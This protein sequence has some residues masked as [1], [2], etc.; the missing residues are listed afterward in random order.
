M[1]LFRKSHQRALDVM[2]NTLE[3]EARSK[4]EVIRQ[5]KKLEQEMIDLE[6]LLEETNRARCDAEKSFKKFNE[7]I[8]DLELVVEDE[9]LA[10]QHAKDAQAAA[11]KK[12]AQLIA[13][14][15]VVRLELDASERSNKSLCSDLK[16]SVDRFNDL[17]ATNA[18]LAESKRLLEID[19]LALQVIDRH[20]LTS[21]LMTYSCNV[22]TIL[23]CII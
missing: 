18:G 1:D 15:Q 21:Y 11:E 10:N 23:A 12:T 9:Q 16:E 6:N 14:L 17:T 2:Q 19:I 7:Q 8:A 3:T 4:V 5:R 20:T 22:R 13:E